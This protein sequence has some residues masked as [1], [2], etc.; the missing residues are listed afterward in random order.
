MRE[1]KRSDSKIEEGA[2]PGP[3][4]RRYSIK[5]WAGSGDVKLKFYWA[6]NLKLRLRPPLMYN[7]LKWENYKGT[8]KIYKAHLIKNDFNYKFLV[9][10]LT[11]NE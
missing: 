5:I 7:L 11:K 9:T 1:R 10:F 3:D 6:F 8:P 2:G 4:P